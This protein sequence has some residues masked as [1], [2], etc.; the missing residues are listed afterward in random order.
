MRRVSTKRFNEPRTVIDSIIDAIGAR[1]ENVSSIS[2]VRRLIEIWWMCV[3]RFHSDIR[4]K[5]AIKDS[6][7]AGGILAGFFKE[8]SYCVANSLGD[9]LDSWLNS[10]GFSLTSSF[11][12]LFFFGG[13]DLIGCFGFH[14]ITSLHS[15]QIKDSLRVLMIAND[16]YLAILPAG[17]PR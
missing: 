14:Y 10:S 8:R 4:Q 3:S 16:I 6:F 15:F 13:G 11:F 17:Q 5:T 9:W 2:F 1:C 7:E 12:F